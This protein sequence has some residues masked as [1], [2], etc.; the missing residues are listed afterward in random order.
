MIIKGIGWIL[1]VILMQLYNK[2]DQ[3][4]QK[5]IQNP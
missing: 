2:K 1:V 5:E 4:W 3:A